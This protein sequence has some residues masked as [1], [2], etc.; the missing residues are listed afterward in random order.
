MSKDFF[1]KTLQLSYKPSI[2]IVLQ[3]INY[4]EKIQVKS[5]FNLLT[6]IGYYFI[7][8]VDHKKLYTILLSNK[9]GI[10]KTKLMISEIVLYVQISGS[11][12]RTIKH[13]S[14][15]FS[16]KTFHANSKLNIPNKSSHPRTKSDLYS[17]HVLCLKCTSIRIDI[18]E[19]LVKKILNLKN[20]EKHLRC[21]CF[22]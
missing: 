21:H 17:M 7:V 6:L 3:V 12:L 9:Y 18:V 10:K 11:Y 15:G 19:L 8:F 13:V 2:I 20:N 16:F 4:Y 14:L 1:V 22:N 5:Q